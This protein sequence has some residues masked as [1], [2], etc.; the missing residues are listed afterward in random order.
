MDINMRGILRVTVKT[1]IDLYEE[2][3]TADEIVD[4]MI[5]VVPKNVETMI[6]TEYLQKIEDL[7]QEDLEA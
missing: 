2:G 7:V 4:Q 1:I 5:A 3:F 6:D